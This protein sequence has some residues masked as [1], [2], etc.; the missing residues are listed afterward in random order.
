MSQSIAIGMC[1][2]LLR[3]WVKRSEW[4][5]CAGGTLSATESGH[6]A[7]NGRQILSARFFLSFFSLFFVFL[8]WV[9]SRAQQGW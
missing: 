1:L 5:C 4:V 2:L 3:G 6:Y 8:L 7:T 9:W